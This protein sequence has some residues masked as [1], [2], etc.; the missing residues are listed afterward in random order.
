MVINE[1]NVAFES[2]EPE[3]LCVMS[4]TF[5]ILFFP[6]VPGVEHGGVGVGGQ[7]EEVWVYVEVEHGLDV[8][9]AGNYCGDYYDCFYC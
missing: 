7:R 3:I 5:F 9:H 6:V 8:G 1:I 2:G 4:I